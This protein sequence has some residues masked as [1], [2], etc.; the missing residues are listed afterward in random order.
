VRVHVLGVRGST[1]APGEEFA[2]YGG[3]T[4]CLALAE[5][6]APPA[7][8]L[9]A[10]TGIRRLTPLL[11]GAPFAGTILLTHLHWD[12]VLGL[13]FFPGGDRPDARA[14]LLMPAQGD[15]R[16]VLAR[17]MSPPFF[18]I[19]PEA[20][21]GAWTFGGLEEGTAEVEG[22][23]VSARALPHGPGRTFGYRVERD[24]ASLAYL[25]DH[26]PHLL[27]PGEHGLGPVHDAARALSDGVDLLVHDAQLTAAELPGREHLGHAS[28][29]YALELARACGARRL[30]LFHHAPDRTDEEI[31]A[32]TAR[33]AAQAPGPPVAAAAEE[34]VIDLGAVPAG[35]APR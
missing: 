32:L 3:H 22:F 5:A 17:V 14:R 28:A 16:E 21:K 35:P 10:G 8:V 2:R 27:G 18:P 4:S 33:I 34:E 24:G 20:L 1:A 26:G 9:D 23:R 13:P 31:A 12:H 25:P 19:G 15:A 29:E 6:G 30:L 7:L 11:E